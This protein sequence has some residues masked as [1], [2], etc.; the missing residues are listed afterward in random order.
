MGVANLNTRPMY[1]LL[2]SKQALVR[3]MLVLILAQKSRLMPKLVLPSNCLGLVLGSPKTRA[4]IFPGHW[5][6]WASS[7]GEQVVHAIWKVSVDSLMWCAA[8]G[9]SR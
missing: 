1:E 2:K 6:A 7:G 3:P 9:S 8:T 4:S 5:E